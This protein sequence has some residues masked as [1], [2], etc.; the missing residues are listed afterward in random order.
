MSSTPA[1][2]SSLFTRLR[3]NQRGVLEIK[4]MRGERKEARR[5]FVVLVFFD[6]QLRGIN[7]TSRRP[8]HPSEFP[9]QTFIKRSALF[10][11]YS[12]EGL[13]NKS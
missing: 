10:F 13:I 5:S 4:L 7:P 12:D 9:S 6:V 1:R 3:R 8:Q 2:G 11:Q